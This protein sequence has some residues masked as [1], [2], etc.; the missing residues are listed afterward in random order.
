MNTR[1]DDNIREALFLQAKTS[2]IT[3]LD[4][5]QYANADDAVVDI[6]RDKMC[7]LSNEDISDAIVRINEDTVYLLQ[8]MQQSIQALF[9]AYC[10]NRPDALELVMAEVFKHT[11]GLN[12]HAAKMFA[13]QIYDLTYLELETEGFSQDEIVDIF[14]T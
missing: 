6:M 8:K 13:K 12:K 9:N 3:W 11:I 2:N 4:I 10:Y 14:N 7:E 1:A 5:L